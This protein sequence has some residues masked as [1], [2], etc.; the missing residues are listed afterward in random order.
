MLKIVKKSTLFLLTFLIP[1]SA[2]CGCKK[3][4]AVANNGEAA[5]D[6]YNYIFR[7]LGEEKYIEPAERFAGGTGTEDDPYQISSAAELALLS[8]VYEILAETHDMSDERVAPYYKAS[9][10]LTDDIVLNERASG[11]TPEY[12]WLPIG[13]HR[14]FEGVFDGAGHTISGLYIDTNLAEKNAATGNSY[15]LFGINNGTIKNVRL[16]DA[17]LCVSGYTASVGGIAGSNFLAQSTVE[18]CEVNGDIFCYDAACGGI[19]GDGGTVKNCSFSGKVTCSRPDGNGSKLGGIAGKADAIIGCKNSGTIHSE[20]T[21]VESIGGIAGKCPSISDCENTGSVSGGY[22]A[23]GIVGSCALIGGGGALEDTKADVKS[24][25]NSGD[26]STDGSYAGGIVGTGSIDYS[27]YTVTVSDCENTGTVYANGKIGG[28]VGEIMLRGKGGVKVSGCENGA[29]LNGETVGGILGSVNGLFGTLSVTGCKN[30]GG[31]TA[32]VYGAGITAENNLMAWEEEKE[33]PLEITISDCENTGSVTTVRGGGVAGVFV[34]TI[35][36]A[37]GNRVTLVLEE[38]VNNADIFCTSDNSFVGG[39]AG[40]VGVPNGSI[41]VKNCRTSGTIQYPELKIDTETTGI[42]ADE[43]RLEMSRIGGGIVGMIDTG[44]WLS[45]GGDGENAAQVNAPDAKIV[46]T[47]CRSEMTFSAPGEDEYVYEDDGTPVFLNHF[48]GVIGFCS[49][50][51]GL[52][53]RVNDCTYTG[54]SRGLGNDEL[55]DV[56]TKA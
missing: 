27:D 23:G 43:A 21:S 28:I 40:N 49:D 13:F 2:M 4:N 20:N 33:N 55:P 22:A 12:S 48:G 18:N 37:S 54:C 15:G 51:A 42:K 16:E 50:D 6:G 35:P 39:I 25:K 26:V 52:A 8:E 41:T 45:T 3:D 46:F 34:N 5:S 10:V 1:L 31:I 44:I 56:G 53:F 47:G 14:N 17:Y 19:V 9:F 24:C 32:S 30:S 7:D 29:A 38:N 36:E 11:G